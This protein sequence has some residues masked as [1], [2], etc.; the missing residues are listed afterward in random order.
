MECGRYLSDQYCVTP[1]AK[2]W[3]LLDLPLFWQKLPLYIV[4]VCASKATK[5][6]I[7]VTSVRPCGPKI[8]SSAQHIVFPW[9]TLIIARLSSYRSVDKAMYYH[10]QPTFLLSR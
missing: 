3:S 2:V 1:F 6:D 4:T 8:D 10:C 7:V 9:D 5:R